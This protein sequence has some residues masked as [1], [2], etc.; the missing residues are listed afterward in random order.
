MLLRKIQ[1]NNTKSLHFIVS[2]L[3][4]FSFIFSILLPAYLQQQKYT[5]I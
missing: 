2:A 5:E 3:N 4:H 1:K